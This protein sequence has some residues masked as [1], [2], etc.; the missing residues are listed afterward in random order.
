MRTRI[1]VSLVLLSSPLL[2]QTSTKASAPGA[3]NVLDCVN[4]LRDANGGSCIEASSAAT[5]GLLLP[6]PGQNNTFSAPAVIAGGESN[7]ASGASAFIGGG[8]SNTASAEYSVIGGGRNNSATYRSSTVAG[9]RSNHASGYAEGYAAVGGGRSNQSAGDYST[10]S[11]GAYNTASGDYYGHCSVGGGRSNTASGDYSTVAGGQSNLA[12]GYVSTVGGG[13]SNTALGPAATIGGGGPND[14]SGGTATVSGG[15]FNSAS[16]LVST[17][18]G[19]RGNA[20]SGDFAAIGGGDGNTASGNQAT[21]P[22]GL[23][24]TALGDFCWAAGRRAKANHDGAFVWGDGF[25][26]DKT[27]STT[28][29]FNVY[30]SGG[31]R[32]FSDTSATA[33]VQLAAGAGSWTS[34]SDRNSKENVEQVDTRQI[35]DKL[36]FIPISTWNYKAQEDAIRHMGPMAQDFYAAFGLGLGDTTIDAIDPDGVALA[37]IQGLNAKLT[38]ENSKL[39][40]RV[41][42]LESMRDEVASLKCTVDMMAKQRYRARTIFTAYNDR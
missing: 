19:G 15:A 21:V 7:G 17:V 28:N 10:V 3:L 27:S 4:S 30:A 35:L 41:D 20:S 9:G 26:G 5:L 36:A 31:T 2:A 13:L 8:L 22:G 37:A 24:N 14:A 29:Q 18:G 6:Y 42:E 34:V 32:I 11:G 23:T 40:A 33:G 39:R 16:G 1:L 12:L 38:Q 25:D